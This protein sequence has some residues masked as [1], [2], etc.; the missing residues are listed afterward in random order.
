MSH[1]TRA[2]GPIRHC[3]SPPDLYRMLD[4][5]EASDRWQ[6]IGAPEVTRS[7]THWVVV[8]KIW[9]SVTIEDRMLSAVAPT[10]PDAV[11]RVLAMWDGMRRESCV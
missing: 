8:A 1:T 3:D 6:V 10:R 4:E 7:G 9:D 11:A 2:S 5:I